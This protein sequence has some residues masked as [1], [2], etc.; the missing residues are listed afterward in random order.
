MKNNRFPTSK[1]NIRR[2][3]RPDII[4]KKREGPDGDLQPCLNSDCH[5]KGGR[6]YLQGC[7]MSDQAKKERLRKEYHASKGARTGDNE[8]RN[9]IERV[10]D[11]QSSVH[12]MLFKAIF[13]NGAVKTEVMTDKNLDMN[14]LPPKLFEEDAR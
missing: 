13:V 5:E 1:E 8:K 2:N 6:H 11:T 4:G 3:Q 10:A 9:T 12:S 14:L 7:N